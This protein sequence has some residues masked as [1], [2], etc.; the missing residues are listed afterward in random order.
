MWLLHRRFYK[1]KVSNE[2]VFLM[3]T[4]RTTR[5]Q[6]FITKY[7]EFTAEHS[8]MDKEEIFNMTLE[9]VKQHSITIEEEKVK[10][11]DSSLAAS[12]KNALGQNMSE[13]KNKENNARIKID[14]NEI[15]K[16]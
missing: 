7:Q 16:D 1:E 9:T 10:A 13:I 8:T 4:Q 3:D 5:C 14:M 11:G 6:Q 2:N 15:V 12:F